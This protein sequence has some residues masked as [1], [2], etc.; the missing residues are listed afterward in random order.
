[1]A[2]VLVLC[3]HAVSP[4]W[5]ATFSVSPDA[6]ERQLTR[7]VRAGWRGAPF[8]DAVLDP[9]ADKTLAVTFDDGFASVFDL[10]EPILSGLGL[11]GTVFAPAAFMSTRQPLSWQGIEAWLGTRFEDELRCMSWDDLGCLAERGWEIGSHTR[12]HRHLTTLPNDELRDEL[13]GSFEECS[14]QLG[15]PCRS[16]AYPYGEVDVRVAD[17]AREAGYL[18]GACLAHSLVPLGPHLWPR[19]GI[20]HDDSDLRFRLKISRLTRNARAS[21]LGP[22]LSRVHGWRA[23]PAPQT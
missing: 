23:L 2:D 22:T 19:V 9:P 14:I 7:L 21:R 18:T 12:S 16:I 5:N 17:Q 6:L 4:T 15:R 13:R 3:Y 20:W 10:A 1:V 11:P 8:T